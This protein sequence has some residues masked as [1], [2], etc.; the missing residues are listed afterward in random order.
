MTIEQLVD[1]ALK[2]RA[3]REQITTLLDAVNQQI[4]ELLPTGGDIDGHKVNVTYRRSLNTKTLEKDYPVGTHPELYD[5]KISTTKIRKNFAPTALE[6]YTT[7]S[8]TPT[9]TIR[10]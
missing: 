1:Q 8:S 3:E 9:V 7:T 2:L 4:A 6:N 10:G 5:M